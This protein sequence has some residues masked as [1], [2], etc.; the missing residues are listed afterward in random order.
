M[1]SKFQCPQKNIMLVLARL[2]NYTNSVRTASLNMQSALLYSRCTGAD[3]NT[4]EVNP[5]MVRRI[6]FQVEHF[7]LLQSYS[8]EEHLSNFLSSEHSY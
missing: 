5:P 6:L 7:C 4:S 2:L 1:Y 8:I 3:E